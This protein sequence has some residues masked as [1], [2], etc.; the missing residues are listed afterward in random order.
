MSKQDIIKF[1]L[2]RLIQCLHCENNPITCDATDADEDERGLCKL[3]KLEAEQDIETI[4]KDFGDYGCCTLSR[5][6]CESD[7]DIYS[8]KECSYYDKDFFARK[9]DG[10]EK[11]L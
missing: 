1:N 11:K 10:K 2:R 9:H 8:C 7:P 3:F 4:T 6:I 5:C